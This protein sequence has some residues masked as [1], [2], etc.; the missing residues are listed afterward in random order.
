MIA[1]LRYSKDE[2]EFSWYIPQTDFAE[3]RPGVNNLIFSQVDMATKDSWDKVTG[4]LVTSYQLTD[5]QM[6]F[7]SYSTGYKSGGFDSLTP[8][9]ESFSPEDT[10]NYE[11]GYKAVLWDS[12]VANVSAYY[13][14]LDNLQHS[15]SSKTP[16][17]LQAVPTIINED[18]E[19][20]GIE[21]D[22]H[23][24]VNDSL[25]LGLVTE[26][27]S[28]DT[29][30]PDFYNGEGDLIEAQKTSVDAAINY[31]VMVDWIPD[32]GI[33]NTNL[34]IDYVFTEN[35]NHLQVGLEDY[36]KPIKAYFIDT[37]D[38]NAR[39][40]WTSDKLEIGLWGKNLLNK[41][42]MF[43]IGGFAADVLGVPHGRIN[44]GLEAGIDV[45]YSF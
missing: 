14:E 2:K 22:F 9:M 38:L 16:D 26:I 34:H 13:L 36:K 28:T 11:I 15:I 7:A 37:K 10:T 27:R 17:S 3:V 19:I 43:S 18:R 32:F 41:R 39:F 21:F 25:K 5:E 24:N 35:I 42:Y 4:R 40:S 31:T 30:S 8:S 23:W 29:Y 44:R 33:G 12:V 20:T 45:K 1:G 6:I